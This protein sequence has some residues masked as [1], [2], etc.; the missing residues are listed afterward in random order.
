MKDVDA[1]GQILRRR[2]RNEYGSI[3]GGVGYKRTL[4]PQES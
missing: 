1:R 4:V 3:K 2:V